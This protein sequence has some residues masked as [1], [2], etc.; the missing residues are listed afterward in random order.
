V[1]ARDEVSEKRARLEQAL[2]AFDTNGDFDIIPELT[3]DARAREPPQRNG[4]IDT[5]PN[6]A[7]VTLRELR[8]RRMELDSRL[9]DLRSRFG[10]HNIQIVSVRAD[11]ATVNKQIDIEKQNVLATMKNARDIAV[12]REQ[13]LEASLHSLAA[14]LNS[15]A[16]IKLQQLRHVADTDNKEY[17]SYLSQYNDISERRVLQ[18][19]GARIISPATLPRSPTSSR[20]KFYAL[21]GAAGLTGGL[22]L[23]FLLEYFRRGIKTSAQVEQSFGLPV[24]G[25]IPLVPHSKTFSTSYYRPLDKMLNEPLSHL[26]EAVRAVRISLCSMNLSRT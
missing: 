19:A 18:G 20:L 5:I 17:Q 24:L 21:G 25:N 2:N 4:D 22:L 11:L 7:S 15:E 14:R 23:A 12:R 16:Y 8:R 26:S 3:G 6:N 9:A 13:D 1:T 10:E